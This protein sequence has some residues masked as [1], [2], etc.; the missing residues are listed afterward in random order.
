[1]MLA[2]GLKSFVPP[3][4]PVRLSPYITWAANVH[5]NRKELAAITNALVVFDQ[6]FDQYAKS[7]RFMG[8]SI[9]IAGSPEIGIILDEP[10]VMGHT[11]QLII[12]PVYL[13]REKNLSIPVMIVCVL[14][15]LCH[16]FYAEEDEIKVQHLVTACARHLWPNVQVENLYHA[17]WQS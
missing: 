2:N 4:T 8:A 11:A 1:M 9:V 14:E 15:E 16:H 3:A 6:E 12:L 7:H 5:P 17:D 13:W 10:D